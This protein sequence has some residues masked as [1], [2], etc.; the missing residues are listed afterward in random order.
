MA[1]VNLPGL[2]TQPVNKKIVPPYGD[3]R[4]RI[5]IV[6]EAP[7]EDEVKYGRPFVGLSGQLLT[8]CCHAA[9]VISSDLYLTNVVKEH[10]AGN[11]IESFYNTKKHSFTKT[12]QAY[13]DMLKLELERTSANVIVAVGNTALTALT[14]KGSIMKWRGS[15]LESTL[16]PGR[17][18]IP[19]IHPAAALREYTLRWIIISDLKRIDKQSKFPGIIRPIRELKI[20]PSFIEAMAYLDIILEQKEVSF[21]I[22]V[23]NQ[24]TSHISFS[25]TPS[26]A[27]SIDFTGGR[28]SEV[29]EMQ[30]WLKIAK[31]LEN[32]AIDKIG[33]NLMFDMWFLA[34]NN[35]II[36]K[37][38]IKDTMIAQKWSYPDFAKGLDFICS[39]YTE[40]PYYKDDGK[41]W[42]TG[43]FDPTSFSLY[44]A[45]DAAVTLECWYALEKEMEQMG[46]R[47]T[48]DFTT[49]LYP[50]FIYM[51]LRG[52]KADQVLLKEIKKGI[53]E[54]MQTCLSKLY[55]V[56]GYELNPNSP[57]QC[58]KHFYV[59]KGLKPYIDRKTHNPTTNDMAMTRI[60]RKGFKEAELIQEF[61]GLNKLKGTYLD[62][63]FDPDSRIRCSINP[64]GTV[65]GRIST[66]QTIFGTGTNLQNLPKE[67]KQ[68]LIADEGM[69]MIEIDKVQA[70]WIET[71][72][73]SGDAN[74]IEVIDKKLD[75]H[76]KTA[77][78]MFPG[79][80]AELVMKD[81]KLIGNSTDEDFIKETREKEIPGIFQFNPIKTMSCRQ[82]AKKCNHGL[83][84]DLGYKGF[85]ISADIEENT[86]KV[87][88]NKYHS[89]YPG[90]RQW[91]GRVKDELLRTRTLTNFFGRKR[92]FLDRWGDDLWKSSY[93]QLPA[94]T[95]ADMLN[96]GIRKTYKMQFGVM[97]HVDMLIQVHDSLLF[98]YPL[99][100][101][102]DLPTVI[103]LIIDVMEPVITYGGRSHIV[104]TDVKLGFDWKHMEDLKFENDLD[105]DMLFMINK[106]IEK[107][108]EYNKNSII[109]DILKE[110]AES[111]DSSTEVI[112]CQDN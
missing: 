12:G 21:D 13:V 23:V 63:A 35:G 86:S 2:D 68:F 110:V 108:K 1:E 59:I 5:V 103:R 101:I 22:E 4:A 3:L 6:G 111:E 14:G 62:I 75:A 29:E 70:E 81:H 78:M 95:V 31:V 32:P 28:Y 109:D 104:P 54:R 77:M 34:R 65:E 43:I 93:A 37:G 73:L 99:K 84:Y 82:I 67:F 11:N 76:V 87:M 100:Y 60:A 24:E 8:Q 20:F 96:N 45:K 7:G 112:S 61:R 89:G 71:A 42:K 48:H 66:S 30:L 88:V 26:Y 85:A 74:M 52:I 47:V 40:E 27:M 72:Y 83:N 102:S 46:T 49:S 106:A 33:Q 64:A 92:K 90:V 25:H 107:L 57:K 56:V 10:P 94:S 79:I 55:E 18:V 39:L 44:S 50:A 51:Q 80:S 91:H 58:C 105:E 41:Q 97:K 38:R 15:I 9:G 53:E 16:L 98:Q 19:I 17:K 36:T 69:V